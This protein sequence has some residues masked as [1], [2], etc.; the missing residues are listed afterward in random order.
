MSSTTRVQAPHRSAHRCRRGQ[1]RTSDLKAL[2]KYA[3]RNDSMRQSTQTSSRTHMLSTI[4]G[5]LAAALL[6]TTA[7]GAAA[8]SPAEVPGASARPREIL[9]GLIASPLAQPHPVI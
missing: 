5:L 1:D 3:R 8:K 7:S 4:V 6:L 9:T 2:S